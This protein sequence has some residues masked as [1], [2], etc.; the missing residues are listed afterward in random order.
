MNQTD[1]EKLFTVAE[2][3]NLERRF[4]DVH[5]WLHGVE[6]YALMLFAARGPGT[7]EIVEIGSWMGR[8]TCWLAYG[9]KSHSREKVHAVDPFDGGPMLSETDPVK[10]E[11]TTYFSFVDNLTKHELFDHVIPIVATSTQAIKQWKKP[12]RLLFIDAEHTYS[13]VKQDFELWTRFLIVN[14]VVVFDDVTNQY[15]G[16]LQFYEELMANSQEYQELLKVGKMKFVQR[17]S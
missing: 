9:S 15:P 4:S 6:G 12:V 1:M 3:V 10:N 7:G 5:G 16:V 8:S 2:Y 14:G 13:A 17:I 11:G